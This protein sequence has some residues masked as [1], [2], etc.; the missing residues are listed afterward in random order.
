MSV[1]SN[2]QEMENAVTKAAAAAGQCLSWT[3]I[4]QDNQVLR[5]SAVLPL[6]TIVLMTIQQNLRLLALAQV[7]DVVNKGAKPAEA[8]PAGMKEESEEVEEDQEI[9]S[10][11]ETT[12]EEVVSEEETTEEEVVAE[13]TDETEEEVQETVEAEFSVEEDV[14]ALFAGEELS[15]EF[16]DKARTIFETAISRL[17][18]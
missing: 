1:G 4:L 11:E 18:K 3:W 14:N 15:E 9:V 10:E 7:K 17:R 6:K 13:A 8:M 5:I 12:E 16:Q 2:L